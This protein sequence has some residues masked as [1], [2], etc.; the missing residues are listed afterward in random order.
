MGTIDEKRQRFAN[1]HAEYFM[2][3]LSVIADFEHAALEARAAALFA[4]QLDVGKKLHFDGDGAVA[5]AGFAAASRHVERKM[6]GG[7]AAA[8]GVGDIRKD[9]ADGVEGFEI[10][11]GIRARRAADRRLIDDDDFANFGITFEAVAE[12]L[13]RC[14]QCAWPASALYK[15]S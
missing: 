1:G 14:R 13:V 4:D 3:I 5:L 15:T 11:R 6:S 8:L 12:F 10:G 2:N 9:F 7:V